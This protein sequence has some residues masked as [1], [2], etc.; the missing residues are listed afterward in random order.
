MKE[1]LVQSGI[2]LLP[3]IIEDR[4]KVTLLPF[5]ILDSGLIRE[6]CLLRYQS[7]AFEVDVC[8][9]LLYSRLGGDGID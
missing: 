3:K 5:L 8:G 4:F 9:K 2:G 6:L 1:L 7:G